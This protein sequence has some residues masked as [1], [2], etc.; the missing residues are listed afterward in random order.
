MNVKTPPMGWN[1]WNTFGL[2]CCDELIRQS[3]DAMVDLGL[4]DAGYEYIV[5]DDGWSMKQRDS[6]TDELV[7][8]PIKFP[9]GM[10]AV[11]DYIHSRGLKFGMYSCC[12]IRT[13][14]NYPG[15]F[16]HEFQDAKTFAGYGVDLL[17]YDN[18]FHPA[19]ANGPQLY[20]RMGTALSLCGRDIVF[21]ACNWGKDDVWSWIR[22]AGAHMYRSTYDLK[23]NFKNFTTFGM[24][25]YDGKLQ[26]SAPNCFNDLDMMTVGMYGE[27][28]CGTEGCN[29]ANYE[30]Q[31]AMWC[32]A[33]S[34]LF[35][36]CDIRKLSEKSMAIL[37]N[38][39]LIAI[40]QDE[41][42]RPPFLISATGDSTYTTQCPTYAKR[43]SNGDFAIAC[44]N[45]A[46]RDCSAHFLFDDLG[47]SAVSGYGLQL[48]DL[49][50]GEE[51]DPIR[52]FAS[53]KVP[54]GGCRIFRAKP[55]KML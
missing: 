17:K 27:G 35:I 11:G 14:G 25:Q 43:L 12:G 16:D 1:T 4:R 54:K 49:Y 19:N 7:P 38:K 36:G 8:D 40:D 2:E 55:V 18:C 42:A 24:S 31:F 9:N 30:L 26:Y 29:D 23:D 5:I 45:F 21:S 41:D 15:S 47:L 22:S 46:D 34:P 50:S 37:T 10:K 33:S 13:C 53:V 6:K 32:M 51:M 44:F 39:E 52:E 3:A 20:H 28:F 48:T